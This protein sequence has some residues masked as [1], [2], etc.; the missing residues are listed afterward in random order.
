M[1]KR[2]IFVKVMVG[3]FFAVAVSCAGKKQEPI[4]CITSF[5]CPDGQ[6]CTEE[7]W[8][9][10]PTMVDTTPGPDGTVVGDDGTEVTESEAVVFPDETDNND[11]SGDTETT[12]EVETA[13]DGADDTLTPDEDG[14]LPDDDEPPSPCGNGTLDEGEECDDGNKDDNDACRNDCLLNRCGDGVRFTD[15]GA[16]LL[17]PFN[18][19][20]GQTADDRSGFGNNG[21][22]TGATWAPGRFGNGLAFAGGGT[23]AVTEHASLKLTVFTVA[24]WVKLSV[25][26]S[27][28]VGILQKDGDLVRNYGLF[29]AGSDN[30]G[31]EGK[32]LLSLTS[33]IPEDWKGVFSQTSI[34]DGR[35]HHVL[36]IYDGSVMKIF[37]DGVW[38]G[39]TQ[40]DVVPADTNG[41][42]LVGQK[43]PGW[44][45]DVR[46]YNRVL[47]AW[48]LAEIASARARFSFDEGGGNTV[49]DASGNNLTGS[50][51]GVEWGEGRWG[52][53]LSFNGA[54]GQVTVPHSEWLDLGAAMTIRLWLKTSV[55]PSNWVRILG[56]SE[57]S[58][59]NRNYG[60][61]IEPGTGKVLFQIEST[62]WLHLLSDSAVTDGQW[63]RIEATY[64]GATARLLIDGEVR[65]ET[66]FTGVPVLSSGPLTIGGGCALS[67][68]NGLIDEVQVY[69]RSL[70]PDQLVLLPRHRREL[71]D[72]GNTVSGDGCSALCQTE[73]IP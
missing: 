20:K 11:D 49:F 16:V 17:L 44:I 51:V 33:A 73:P 2:F 72:D 4:P 31:N 58:C 59:L 3:I 28:Y 18:E 38:H 46:I 61:W 29:V 63:H 23:V 55:I 54:A 40:V 50:L 68:V 27:G 13:P 32:V 62:E 71:C 52:N 36:G 42:V 12:T 5:D 48:E 39:E 30:P 21:V 7:G 9:A 22:I 47:E 57:P 19:G 24:A 70:S 26:P 67:P 69:G 66:P 14:L 37:V 1:M 34:V 65:A 43:F 53:A 10:D 15:P 60:I 45:D 8:C 6:T 56:K 35:W 25:M 41:G 64:N